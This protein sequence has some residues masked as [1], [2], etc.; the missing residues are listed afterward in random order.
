[1]VQVERQVQLRLWTRKLRVVPKVALAEAGA[2]VGRDR[3]FEV[4]ITGDIAS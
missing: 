1:M 3:F 4:Q 2:T